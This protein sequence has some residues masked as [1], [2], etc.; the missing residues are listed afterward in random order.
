MANK[1]R[2]CAVKAEIS[3]SKSKTFPCWKRVKIPK[4][5]QLFHHEINFWK[6][7][8]RKGERKGGAHQKSRVLVIIIG[9]IVM[10]H[11]VVHRAPFSSFSQRLDGSPIFGTIQRWKAR[12]QL[13]CLFEMWTLPKKLDAT[14]RGI[15]KYI[16]NC[17]LTRAHFIEKEILDR[18]CGI[19]N[20]KKK[21]HFLNVKTL[22]LW[23]K[24][25][26]CNCYIW[27]LDHSYWIHIYKKKKEK[28]I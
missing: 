10:S 20:A 21:S 23:T 8:G 7:F 13:S 2:D 27:F 6:I 17:H 4:E 14:W 9:P 11:V 19:I 1:K 16:E 12:S 15:R 5:N 22:V 28:K 3:K 18:K 25:S 24:N 26:R